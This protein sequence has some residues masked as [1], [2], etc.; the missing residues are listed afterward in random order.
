MEALTEALGWTWTFS[1]SQVLS[2]QRISI[3]VV[4]PVLSLCNHTCD[5]FILGCCS[6]SVLSCSDDQLEDSD[7]DEHSRAESLTGM[8]SWPRP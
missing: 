8:T 5:C 1:P 6:V 4:L 2:T 3:W 7:S